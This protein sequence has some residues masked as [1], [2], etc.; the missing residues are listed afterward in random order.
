MIIKGIKRRDYFGWLL[1]GIGLL[2]FAYILYAAFDQLYIPS[3]VKTN[4]IFCDAENV[5]D[6]NFVNGKYEFSNGKTQSSDKSYSGNYSSHIT[7]EKQYGVGYTLKK[8][9]KN[10]L[11]SVTVKRWS[12]RPENAYLALKSNDNKTI[13]LQTANSESTDENGWET[14]KLE[15]FLH[16]SIDVDA[17]VSFVYCG[18][19]DCNAYFDDF[20]IQITDIGLMNNFKLET[21]K[22]YLDD[23]ALNT[24]NSVRS[25][26]L[27]KGILFSEDEDWVKANMTIDDSVTVEVD[28]RLKG[29][30]TDHLKGDYWSYRIKMPSDKSWNRLQT[31]SL[32]D[33]KTRYYLYEWIYHKAMEE[34]DIITPRYGF[35]ELS[36][37][38][39]PPVLYAYEEHFEKQIAEYRNRREGVIIKH[40]EDQI[41]EDR[42]RNR[43]QDIE[44]VYSN[45][46]RNAETA[47]FKTSKTLK[48]P[49]LKE[50]FER[51][52]D[53]MY[54]H[55]YKLKPASEIFDMERMGKFYAL[56]D[57]LGAH[58]SIIWHNFRFYYN[59]VTRKL[60]PIGYDGFTESGPYR[61]YALL[62]F[63]EYMSSSHENEWSNYYKDIF[64]DPEFSKYYVDALNTFS[65]PEYLNNLFEKYRDEI[66]QYER[67]IQLMSDSDYSFEKEYFIKRARDI[68]A[69][70]QPF[71]NQS[72][73]AYVYKNDSVYVSNYHVLPLEIVGS[74][75][76]KNVEEIEANY[77]KT[78]NSNPRRGEPDY[79]TIKVENG[80]KYVYYRMSG[81]PKIYYTEIRKWDRPE[82]PKINYSETTALQIPLVKG[83]EYGID[84]NKVIIRKGSYIVKS[85]III[86][87]DKIVYIEPG[88]SIALE[89][90]AF[91]L[92]YSTVYSLGTIDDPIRIFSETGKNQGFAVLGADNISTL[93]YTSFENLNTLEENEWQLTG[94]VTFYESDL[95]VKN[96]T[97]SNNLC[98]DALN[99]V[100]AEVE[101]NELNI[102]NTYAD[103]FDC[104]FCR[105]TLTNS[106]FFKTG[107]DGIDFSGSFIDITN[108]TM[109]TIGDKGISAGEDA[110]L[111]VNNV[112]I[113]GAV[114]GVASKDLSEVKIGTVQLIDCKTGF[115]AYRK[116]PEF[117]GGSII[118]EKYTASNVQ[119]LT[120]PD[121]ESKIELPVAQ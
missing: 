83:K 29:D 33:P 12:N 77:Q 75:N 67:L 80:A 37:N 1:K 8:P 110:T 27:D 104:D 25:E 115:A 114:I 68:H 74:G 3:K 48:T 105:G 39:K 70:I 52:Q 54:A 61:T 10:V 57:L 66:F 109:K 18:G 99:V 5:K 89:N 17:L 60:E 24:L 49:K 73:R 47:A 116:K 30:W 26:A 9:K 46:M 98:E 22:L 63:G 101:V 78:I 2:V 113:E 92:S 112:V 69:N 87:R 55:R 97:I 96:V 91:F 103:G 90:N 13:Y 119:Y 59:P 56:V 35:I 62:F 34:E 93:A 79:E 58:H 36:Q 64:Q 28:L 51:A 4:E 121:A 41:W 50:Q 38:N 82:A 107:N 106:Y 86:P 7:N 88:T 16:D 31:F 108:S 6:K 81:D 120:Q 45:T 117:G 40:V 102:N 65:S 11:Y 32:Q 85:P 15:L 43:G 118:V 20:K 21:L 111:T 95:R 23:K 53:L 71:N 72:M 44:D 19:G 42:L 14:L 84:G 94:A 76:D 100:R